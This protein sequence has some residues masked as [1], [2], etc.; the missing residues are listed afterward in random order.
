MNECGR[1][2][3]KKQNEA[4][5]PLFA[6]RDKGEGSY[7]SFVCVCARALLHFVFFSKLGGASG[8]KMSGFVPPVLAAYSELHETRQIASSGLIPNGL[9]GL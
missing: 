9:M 6:R 8:L 4:S 7:G 3:G 2:G 1:D 5:C